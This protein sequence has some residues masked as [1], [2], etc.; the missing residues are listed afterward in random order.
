[1]KKKLTILGL[2]LTATFAF[3]LSQRATQFPQTQ[4]EW[5]INITLLSTSMD[6][7]GVATKTNSGQFIESDIYHTVQSTVIASNT[8][9]AFVDV[10]LDNAN[11]IPVFTNSTSSGTNTT[12]LTWIGKWSW[13]RSRFTGTNSSGTIIYLGQ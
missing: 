9:A 11:W 12:S 1:M 7:N 2:I 4:S 5:T 6:T 13:I 3:V 8:A 10:S